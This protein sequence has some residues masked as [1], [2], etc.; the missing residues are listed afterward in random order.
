MFDCKAVFFDLGGTLFRYGDLHVPFNQLLLDQLAPHGC[1]PDPDEARRAYG[2]AMAAAFREFGER[3]FYRHADLF[4]AGVRRFLAGFGVPSS[5][6]TGLAFYRAQIALGLDRVEPRPEAAETL[7]ALA[8]A[9]CHVGIVSNIDDDQF[10]PLW[11]RMN[12]DAW[13]DATTTSEEARSCKPDAGIFRAALAKAGSPEPARCLFVGDSPL[14]DVR[15]SREI[16][17]RSVLITSRPERV[18]ELPA[19]ERPDHVVKSLAS[20]VT[21]A[22]P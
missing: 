2:R 19:R 11:D 20:I 21:L 5:D 22:L 15:G 9:G 10:A 6:E 4:C 16:G 17:M 3:P 12:L 1:H 18:E 14:H 13:V 8:D 7:R